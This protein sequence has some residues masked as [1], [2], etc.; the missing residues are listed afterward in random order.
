MLMNI[1]S[2]LRSI[3]ILIRAPRGTGAIGYVYIFGIWRI[4]MRGFV[5]LTYYTFRGWIVQH[6]ASAEGKPTSLTA[7]SVQG[8]GSFHVR[9]TNDA[10]PA[11][12]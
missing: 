11:Q 6:W 5:R 7:L 12:S 3:S 8:P 2:V 1:G 4:T 9:L 10:S